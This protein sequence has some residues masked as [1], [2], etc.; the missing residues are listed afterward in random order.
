MSKHIL[1]TILLSFFV[2]F[3]ANANVSLPAVFADNMVLRQNS[4]VKIWGWAKPKEPISVT[5]SWNGQTATTEGAPDATW[6]VWVDT[7]AGNN[8]SHT[9]KIQG[10]NAIDITNVMIGEVFLCSGQSNMEWSVG[11]GVVGKDSLV[12]QAVQSNIRMFTVDYRTADAPCHD[13]SGRWVV[14][15]PAAVQGFS[16]IGYVMARRISG[17]LNVP[18]GIINSSWGGTP[19]EIWTPSLAYEMCDYLRTANN[20]LTQGEWGPCRPGQAYNAMIAPMGGYALSGIAWYQGEENTRNPDAYTDMMYSLVNG[21]REIFGQDVPFVYAQIAPFPYWANTGVEIRERQRRAMAIPQSAMVVIGDLGDT[22][23]I[24]PRRKIEAGERF[25]N[26]MLNT[27]YGKTEFEYAAP[28]FEK[29]EVVKNK[30]IVTFANA[31]GL[32]C[33]GAKQP[34]WFEVAGDDGVF[35]L[36]K[37]KLKGNTVELTSPKV[38]QPKNVRYA[39]EDTA[40][41]NL[42]N[43]IGVQAS[44]FNTCDDIK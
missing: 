17:E 39:W 8:D 13:V 26:A 14:T 31:E 25:A 28:L 29:M 24:H 22:T 19:I 6:S 4:K 23:D 2:A 18:V 30:A 38:K 10:Y 21:F 36:A 3:S 15:S 42:Y 16:A 27:V 41:P 37:A 35:H 34:D 40:M 20:L 33:K 43:K 1:T 11:A 12:A 7:P 5:T 9:I 32:H 44:C